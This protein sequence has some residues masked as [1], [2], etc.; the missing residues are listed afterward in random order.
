MVPAWQRLGTPLPKLLASNQATYLVF[1]DCITSD[2]MNTHVANSEFAYTWVK[3]V[4]WSE[5]I[6]EDPHLLI[7]KCGAKKTR[8]YGIVSQQINE[9]IAAALREPVKIRLLSIR[10]MQ[11]QRTKSTIH[12]QMCNA[13]GHWWRSPYYKFKT[14]ASIPLQ[15][16][17]YVPVNPR[18]TVR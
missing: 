9:I 11:I 18:L 17:A 2:I 12:S 16:L 13:P 10:P 4:I 5:K 1:D 8:L 7:I 15:A 6:R 3:S 14:L